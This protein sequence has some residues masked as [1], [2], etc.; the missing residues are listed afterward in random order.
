MDL[1]FIDARRE[2]P[3]AKSLSRL[4]SAT[5]IEAPI[6]A[7]T[8]EGGLT[9]L[10]RIGKSLMSFSIPQV[11][12]KLMREFALQSMRAFMPAKHSKVHQRDPP[13]RCCY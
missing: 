5:G 12:P 6:I 4:M 9:A 11:L 10:A 1:V 8:T 7:I 3:T 2:F 13:R